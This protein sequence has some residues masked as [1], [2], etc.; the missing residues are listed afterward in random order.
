MVVQDG[1]RV[2]KESIHKAVDELP[3]ESLYELASFID[4]LQ[5]KSKAQSEG[6]S[7]LREMYDAFAPVREAADEMGLSEAE[8][9]AIIDETIDEVR[10]EG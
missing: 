9:D 6:I 2:R 1:K 7:P 4:F 10:R 8:I 3:V 5:Y